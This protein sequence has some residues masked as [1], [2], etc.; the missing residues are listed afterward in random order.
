M[1]KIN[2]AI[3][4]YSIYIF[5]ATQYN[6]AKRWCE[7]AIKLLN[8]LVTLKDQYEAQVLLKRNAGR[9]GGVLNS[10]MVVQS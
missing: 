4:D 3:H 1:S 9:E 10:N 5:S 8:C 6:D 7:L 2:A